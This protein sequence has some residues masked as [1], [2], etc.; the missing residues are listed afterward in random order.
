MN[1]IESQQPRLV[2]VTTLAPTVLPF[3]LSGAA[4]EGAETSAL[5]EDAVSFSDEAVE[6]TVDRLLDILGYVP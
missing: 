2:P 1:R 3:N 4:N 6:G 5:S